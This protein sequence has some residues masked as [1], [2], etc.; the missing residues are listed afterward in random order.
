[1]LWIISACIMPL[2]IHW[3]YKFILQQI[4]ILKTGGGG[5]IDGGVEVDVDEQSKSKKDDDDDG[6]LEMRR[7]EN[8][9]LDKRTLRKRQ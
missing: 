1:V 5:S 4:R 9:V 2:H 8:V 3:F 6:L 7:E